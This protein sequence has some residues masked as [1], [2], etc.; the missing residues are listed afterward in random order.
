MT[1]RISRRMLLA[2]SAGLAVLP[3]PAAR[4]ASVVED[5]LIALRRHLRRANIAVDTAYAALPIS[6]GDYALFLGE[7]PG[8]YSFLGVR[9][10]RVSITS[11]SPHFGA[12]APDERA[13]GHGVRAMTGWLASRTVSRD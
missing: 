11:S 10:P 3:P 5:D 13:I 6:G 9:G 2:G 1:H 7:L 12:F 8:T 4:P